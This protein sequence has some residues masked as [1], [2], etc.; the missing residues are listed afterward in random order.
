MSINQPQKLELQTESDAGAETSERYETKG[1]ESRRV[2]S[3]ED[4]YLFGN[5][6]SKK[7][8]CKM[9]RPFSSFCLHCRT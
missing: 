4:E 2:V 7:H 8:P 1:E 3:I 9:F 5:H 6:I